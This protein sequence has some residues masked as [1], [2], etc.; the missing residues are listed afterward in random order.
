MSVFEDFKPMSEWLQ[1]HQ[2]HFLI[3]HLPG[4][5]KEQ[6][7][8]SAEG[9]NVIRARGERPVAGNKWSRFQAAF[10]VP[11]DGEMSSIRARFHGQKLTIT[12]PKS[13]VKKP[14]EAPDDPQRTTKVDTREQPIPQKGLQGNDPQAAGCASQLATVQGAGDASSERTSIPTLKEDANAVAHDKL[15]RKNMER[16]KELLETDCGS[17]VIDN[18]KKAVKGVFELNEER[19]LLVNMGAAVLVVVALGAYV[20]YKF[21]SKKDKD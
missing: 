15:T 5:V 16:S 18:Y 9:R 1:D 6:I 17:S 8:V 21:A 14:Q 3:I 13:S 10:Q 20:A 2:S 4:F 19:Q 7:R 11:E 12:V